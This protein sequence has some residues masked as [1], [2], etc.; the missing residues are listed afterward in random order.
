MPAK[1][2]LLI[3]DLKP[4]SR[5]HCLEIHTSRNGLVAYEL[6]YSEEPNKDAIVLHV[7]QFRMRF[8]AHPAGNLLIQFAC[9]NDGCVGLMVTYLPPEERHWLKASSFSKDASLFALRAH[10]Q[11]TLYGCALFV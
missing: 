7:R 9:P 10:A 1:P 2:Y 6:P 8:A 5:Q 3:D 11:Q 4:C